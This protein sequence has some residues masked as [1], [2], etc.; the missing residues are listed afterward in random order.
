MPESL[1]WKGKGVT[2]PIQT[3]IRKKKDKVTGGIILMSQ[4]TASRFVNSRAFRRIFLALLAVIAMASNTVGRSGMTM[5]SRAAMAQ[6]G[7]TEV[8]R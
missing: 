5:T 7:Q 3:V 4:H 2:I 8:A 1:T 6:A